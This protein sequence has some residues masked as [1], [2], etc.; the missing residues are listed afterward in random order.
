[1]EYTK[2]M[3]FQNARFRR[4]NRRTKEIASYAEV[5]CCRYERD[6]VAAQWS[7]KKTVE[8]PKLSTRKMIWI[9]ELAWRCWEHRKQVSQPT[10]IIGLHAF[11]ALRWECVYKVRK[12]WMLCSRAAQK[13]LTLASSALFQPDRT[14][15]LMYIQCISYIVYR[16]EYH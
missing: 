16:S 10:N 11:D 1:M 4:C 14:E 8:R 3:Q 15:Q 7:G 12:R 6:S 9:H 13:E 2:L 5:Y